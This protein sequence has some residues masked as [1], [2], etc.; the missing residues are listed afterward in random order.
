LMKNLFYQLDTLSNFHT[1][2]KPPSKEAK[3][4]TQNVPAM[5]LE[6]AIPINV[7]DAFVKSE[8]EHFVAHKTSLR[9]KEELTKEE[10]RSERANKKRKIKT[11]LK[12]K[13]DKIKNERRKIGLAQAER[14]D[15]KEI[16]RQQEKRKAKQ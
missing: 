1:V 13:S 7:S 10:K 2:P 14:F 15:L 8:K 12:Q 4:L 3:I 6:D 16:K 11:H 9:D 5:M